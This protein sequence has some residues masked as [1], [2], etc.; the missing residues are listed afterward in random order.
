MKKAMYFMALTMMAAMVVAC[1]S[2]QQSAESQEADSLTVENID[3][4]EPISPDYV[5][6]NLKGK[7]KSYE[8]NG[9][10]WK[11][12]GSKVEFD[13]TGQVVI[14]DGKK[15]NLT[16]N[17]KGQIVKYNYKEADEFGDLYDCSMEYQYDENDQLVRI[18]TSNMYD[19]WDSEFER[20]DE[21]NIVTW[22]NLSAAEGVIASKYKY[23]TFDEQGNWTKLSEGSEVTTRKL[24]YWE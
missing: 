4:E 2:K 3:E 20:D 22:K 1:G 16:R 12:L 11:V 7:V 18:K 19:D 5:M 13:E 23:Q 14:I 10:C 15:P 8:I 24:T 21:G 9:F 17:D 6:L